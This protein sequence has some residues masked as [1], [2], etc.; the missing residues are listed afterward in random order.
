MAEP[1]LS[2]YIRPE[3]LNRLAHLEFRPRQLVEGTLAGAHKS[4]F[5]GFSV[6]FEGHREYVPGDDL[7]HLDWKVY[8]RHDRHMVK[9]YEMETNLVA[10]LLL[11]I[12]ASMR[13]GQGDRQ[14][15]L[16][17][18]RMAVALAHLIVEQLDKVSLALF[19]QGLR[20]VLAPSN[21]TAQIIR[22]VEL[23][24]R[25]QPVEKTGIGAALTELAGRIKRRGI[26]IILSDLFVDLDDLERSLQRLRFDRQEVVLFQVLDH[27]EIHF[28]LDGMIRFRG[29]EDLSDLLTRPED[30]RA[31]YLEAFNRF[32]DRLARVCE[33]NRCERLVCDT[34]RP[35]EELF[36]DYLQKRSLIR[37]RW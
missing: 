24:D 29:L 34:S 26:V 20:E 22:M 1:V 21:T 6:E 23:L 5:H 8:Y 18:S 4:P 30:V 31:A 27:D 28:E 17:A 36:A 13:Y 15:L 32:N 37:R 9:Q 25:T 16:Y 10:H 7:R 19:D 11:D 2:K 35:M 3:V 33:S 14:K 12:S